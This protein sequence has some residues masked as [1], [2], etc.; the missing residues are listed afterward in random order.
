M[1]EGLLPDTAAVSESRADIFD[2]PLFPEEEEVV[3]RAVEK[4][5]REFTT[6]RAC[7]RQALMRLGV[8]PQAIPS[9]PK[10][11]PQ[12]P[13]GIVGSITHC[14]GFRACAVARSSQLVTLGVDAEINAPLPAGL[15]GD[16]ALPEE[17]ERL[18]AL[19][20]E[21]PSVSWD[22]LLF[23]AKESVYKAWYPL[24]GRWLGFEDANLTI[25]RQGRTFSARLL[26]PG[27][28]FGG[29]ELTGFSGSWSVEEGIVLSAIA[30]L[31]SSS[32]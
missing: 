17:R 2:A 11:D 10:G 1:L 7:A 15:L 32:R 19:A 16:I 8:M 25:D 13:A 6:A 27:P 23:S 28:Q 26:V 14:E 9:G 30:L 21:D 12:W 22:R 24:A 20:G 18:L 3:A 4:R 29:S 31:A 5:R